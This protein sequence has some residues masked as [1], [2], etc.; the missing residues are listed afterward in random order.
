MLRLAQNGGP[1]LRDVPLA[2]NNELL[3]GTATGAGTG[4]PVLFWARFPGTLNLAPGSYGTSLRVSLYEQSQTGAYRLIESRPLRF[5][6]KVSAYVRAQLEFDGQVSEFGAPRRID[7]GEL[8]TGARQA[9]NINV[10]SNVRYTLTTT[11]DFA[12]NLN[13]QT[14]PGNPFGIFA[15]I[16]FQFLLMQET[17]SASGSSFGAIIEIG[18]VSGAP[19]NRYSSGIVFTVAAM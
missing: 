5:E 14:G 12:G 11:A 17:K 1:V 9:L 18:D 15:S 16:P 3:R 19:A 8:S 7:F 13:A 4:T 10:Q 2:A 6:V